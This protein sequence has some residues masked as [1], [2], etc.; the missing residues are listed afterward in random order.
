MDMIQRGVQG[1]GSGKEK[2]IPVKMALE[3]G[4]LRRVCGGGRVF[5]RLSVEHAA[6]P[7]RKVRVLFR[8]RVAPISFQFSLSNIVS[9]TIVIFEVVQTKQLFVAQ[10]LNRFY[11]QCFHCREK[12]S[13]RTR[14]NKN[15]SNLHCNRKTYGRVEQRTIVSYK[16]RYN[17]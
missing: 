7:V 15:Q 5:H 17:L 9:F 1:N 8:A 13:Q 14:H 2:R 12:S 6:G 3:L 10:C 4:G 16:F 11:F